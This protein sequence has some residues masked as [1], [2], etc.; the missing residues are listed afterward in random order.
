MYIY[1][2]THVK[3]R[4]G[5]TGPVG[6]AKTGPLFFKHYFGSDC[7]IHEPLLSSMW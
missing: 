3:F 7:F 5:G 6:Q 4:A 1:M 2:S